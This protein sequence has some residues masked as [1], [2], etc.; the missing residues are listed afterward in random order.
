MQAHGMVYEQSGQPK[1]RLY[2]LK[3]LRRYHLFAVLEKDKN[4]I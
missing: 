3:S 2:F 1:G 4:D